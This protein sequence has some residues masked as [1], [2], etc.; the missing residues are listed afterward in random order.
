MWYLRDIVTVVALRRIMGAEVCPG[1]RAFTLM[2]LA[3][4]T[5]AGQFDVG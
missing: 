1:Y 5:R 4:N 2:L 3:L